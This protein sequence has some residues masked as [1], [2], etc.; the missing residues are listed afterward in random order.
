MIVDVFGKGV[1]VFL[2]MVVSWILFC[3]IV[4]WGVLLV[5]CFIYVN[6]LLC[7]ESLD[8]MFVM[9]FYG[10]Y[11]YKIGMM[12]Y[13]NVGYNFFYFFCGGWIVECLFVVF[14]FVVGV[15]DDIEFESNILM[16]GIGD[17]LFLY[18]DGV[19]EVFNDKWE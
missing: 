19:I 14:N 10:I 9:V 3:V 1:L 4:F 18:M 8:F 12:D 13:I 6:K 7:K 15:F 17:I 11:Y 2:F 16:F 5:E